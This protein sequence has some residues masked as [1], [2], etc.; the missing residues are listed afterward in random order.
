MIS[1][2]LRENPKLQGI[3]LRVAY[4]ETFSSQREGLLSGNIPMLRKICEIL[5]RQNGVYNNSTEA[6]RV[7]LAIEMILSPASVAL[8]SIP[9]AIAAKKYLLNVSSSNSAVQPLASEKADK[10]EDSYENNLNN[11]H[12]NEVNVGKGS[13]L[14]VKSNG[15]RNR[16]ED[17]GGNEKKVQNVE[18]LPPFVIN[19][20]INAAF[21]ANMNRDSVKEDKED[22]DDDDDNDSLPDIDIDADPEQ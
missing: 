15:K 2:R 20:K 4:A 1:E 3:F 16:D 5:L 17:E 12:K 8:P 21:G 9:V 11:L 18:K 22:N 14:E 13:F 6:A 19:E 10:N 7:L